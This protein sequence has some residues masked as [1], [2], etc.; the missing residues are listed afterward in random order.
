MRSAIRQL[1]PDLRNTLRVLEISGRNLL[2]ILSLGTGLA[3]APA[4]MAGQPSSNTQSF[5]AGNAPEGLAFD[6][7]SVWAVNGLDSAVTK[8]R[9]SDGSIEGV[10]SVGREPHY[11]VFDGAN[12]WV[13]NYEDGTVTKLRASDGI[14]LAT[15]HA[16]VGPF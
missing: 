11:L 12:I 3:N 8:L 16:G 9:A 4:V 6:G 1:L 15:Y 14:F 13:A 2:L 10:F 7:N 5:P